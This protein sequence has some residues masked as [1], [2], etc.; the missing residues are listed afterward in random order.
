MRILKF[1]PT[2][3]SFDLCYQAAIFSNVQLDRAGLKTHGAI[4]DKLEAIGQVKPA[5]DMQ[6]GKERAYLPDEVRIWQTI[7]GGDVVLENAEWELLKT[8]LVAAIPNVGKSLTRELDATITYVE[9]LPDVPAAVLV[10][11]AAGATGA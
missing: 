9:G 1:Q 2:A 5:V 8:L 10:T 6:T 11:D 7:A 4:L 3:R